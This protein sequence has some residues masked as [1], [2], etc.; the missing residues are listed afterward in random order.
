MVYLLLRLKLVIFFHFFAKPKSTTNMAGE[1]KNRIVK[2]G[3]VHRRGAV[4]YIRARRKLFY[5][6]YERLNVITVVYVF[7]FFLRVLTFVLIDNMPG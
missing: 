3:R 7:F 4:F 1:E 2:F 6:F 5:S